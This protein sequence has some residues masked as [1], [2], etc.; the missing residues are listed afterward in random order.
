MKKY[1]TSV[2]S[3]PDVVEYKDGEE[4]EI[5]HKNWSGSNSVTVKTDHN[6][7]TQT[8]FSE[9]SSLSDKE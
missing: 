5:S 1:A 8:M 6:R 2:P 9:M 7:T 3:M 4:Y